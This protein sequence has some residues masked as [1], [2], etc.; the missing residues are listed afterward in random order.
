MYWACC[1]WGLVLFQDQGTQPI[2]A[3]SIGAFAALAG[4]VFTAVGAGFTNWL[5]VRT[6]QK[7]WQRED[8][9][10]RKEQ[11][12]KSRAERQQQRVR[13]YKALIATAPLEAQSSAEAYEV[14]SKLDDALLEVLLYASD[15][16]VE[17]GKDLHSHARQMVTRDPSENKETLELR[18][19]RLQAARKAFLDAVVEEARLE[20]ERSG[21]C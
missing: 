8:E 16:V 19:V 6:Q 18:R 21:R 17:L 5:A 13:A 1:E 15:H 10:R 14:L 12:E 9:R 11:E 3:I 7:Q 4:S 2:G 20:A